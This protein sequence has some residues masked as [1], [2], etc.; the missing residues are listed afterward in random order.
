MRSTRQLSIT[1]PNKMAAMVCARVESG[2]YA[3][4]SEIIRDGLRALEVRDRAFEA[5]LRNDV[6]AAY[7]AMKADP[8]RARSADQVRASLEAAHQSALSAG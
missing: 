4:E 2:E 6:A 1:L 5:W 8:S 3:S 7:D